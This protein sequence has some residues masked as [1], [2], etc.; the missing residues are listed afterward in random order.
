MQADDTSALP[1]RL[2]QLRL[3]MGWSLEDVVKVLNAGSKGVVS[4]WEASTQRRRTPPLGVLLTLARWYGVSL[5]YLVGT[6]GAERDSPRVRKGKA[7]LRERF[8]GEVKG[9]S[10]A[11]PGARMALCIRILQE[12]APEAFFTPR[13]A[14][15]L[16][17]DEEQ[18][19]SMAGT[20]EVADSLLDRFAR[21]ADIPGHWFYQKTEDL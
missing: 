3:E 14:A 16:L 7:A 5:D 18:L 17:V 9:L 20:G 13:I 11:T 4:N 8:P 10:P 6:P 2:K 21:M 1:K 19:T 15:M 12:A